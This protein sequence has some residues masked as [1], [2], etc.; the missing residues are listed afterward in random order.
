[1][2]RLQV[3]NN[4]RVNLAD[5]AVSF[6]SEDDLNDSLQDAYDDIAI[7]TQCINKEVTLTWPNEIGYL[8]FLNNF[9]VDDYLGTVGLFNN[10][11]NRWL[12]DNL[13]IRDL[14]RL[15]RD[16]EKWLGTPLFWAPV[17]FQKIAICP[18]YTGTVVDGAFFGGAFSDAFYIGSSTLG[19]FK[20]AY[21]ATAPVLVNDSS[22]FLIATDM[23]T[24]LEFYCT[25]DL[26]EQA[27]E[28]VKAG[29]FWLKYYRDV[30]T[31]KERV[32]AINRSDL[33]MR[34]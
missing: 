34:V 5:A 23:Q 16:W 25:A 26:L 19:T 24:L 6:Y 2:T 33:L 15:R 14:D 28:Y 30:L 3:K 12:S 10:T 11:N 9:G 32:H 17:N 7:L 18:K 29:A 27:Q 1:M 8:D 13:S 4:V 21:W 22:T 31:Y 20:L